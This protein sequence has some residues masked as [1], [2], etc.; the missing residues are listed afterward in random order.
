MPVSSAFVPSQ[1]A[2]AY[3]NAW[4]SQAAVVIPTPFGD[5]RCGNASGGLCGGMVFANLDYWHSGALP[6][7][8]RPAQGDP[9]FGF[10]VRRLIDSW[11]VPAGVAQY[12]QWMNLPDGDLGFSAFGRRVI[13]ER[14]LAWRTIRV[15][16]PQIVRD[17]DKGLP[18]A[19]GVV[20][21]ASHDP[22]DLALNHQVL[23]YGYE[24]TDSQVTVRVYDPNRGQ[25]DDVTIRF[26]TSS[27]SK[28][29]EFA[30]NL[31]LAH[32]VRG[33]FRTAYSPSAVPAT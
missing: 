1:H 14:G 7:A 32:P 30:H 22:R 5:L 11:H 26:T 3:E 19:L 8:A 33:F 10:I 25:R 20:T 28:P 29:T 15:Q 27:P 23:A 2:F 21:T 12:F 31:D 18:V 9:L 6:P 17:L 4:P 13:V 16:W 24:K